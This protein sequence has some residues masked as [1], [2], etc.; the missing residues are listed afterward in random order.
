MSE[1]DNDHDIDLPDV[2][3]AFL[4]RETYESVLRDIATQTEVLDVLAKGASEEY[5]PEKDIGLDKARELFDAGI[6]RSFQMRYRWD[7]LEW[8]DTV[9]RTPEGVK[10]VRISHDFDEVPT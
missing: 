5:A 4:D 9:M 10:I 1:P 8:R 6:I 7:G 3:E 2:H